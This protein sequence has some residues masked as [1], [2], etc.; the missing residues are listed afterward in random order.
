MNTIAYTLDIPIC[1][2]NL[3]KSLSKKFGWVAKK[4]KEQK[5]CRLDK[6]IK[7]SKTETLFETNDLDILMDS[8]KK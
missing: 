1:D 5:I 8:L 6:A 7:A 3:L 2:V 4:Q